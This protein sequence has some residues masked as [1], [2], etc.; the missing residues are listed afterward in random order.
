MEGKGKRVAVC[1]DG[2]FVGG[3]VDR[4]RLLASRI[5]RGVG[6]QMCRTAHSETGEPPGTQDAIFEYELS[7]WTRSRAKRAM[8]VGI[9]LAFSPILLPALAAIGL[10]VLV[11]SGAPIFFRQERMGR[12]GMPFAIY[13]FRTMRPAV[14]HP[15]SAIAT[16]SA[17][18]ITR[19]GAFL[20]RSKLDELPQTINVLAGE[21]S[22]VGPRP[23]VPEQQPDPFPCRPGVTGA[24]TLAFARE[25]TLLAGIA[26]ADLDAYFTKTILSAKRDLDADYLRRATIWS[27]LW[28]LVKTVLGR[29][30]SHS[31]AA[32]W[33]RDEEIRL[34]ASSETA[35]LSQ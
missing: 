3:H 21:M 11:T 27:D 12:H 29:W 31:E 4:A 28:M 9:V 13:K 32:F 17:G 15:S 24:A 26:P 7:P 33:L 1:D 20:R 34:E 18:R 22:L 23:K 10:A 30:E 5:H 16:A 8:D 35:S 2:A 25:E 14:V 19:L 6:T